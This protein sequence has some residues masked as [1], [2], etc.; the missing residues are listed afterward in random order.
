MVNVLRNR[1]L[2]FAFFV[3]GCVLIAPSVAR[4]QAAAP[5][6]GTLYYRVTSLDGLGDESFAG[7]A[8]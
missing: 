7:I 5:A 4:A 3:L 6:G 8:A 2:G 1:M